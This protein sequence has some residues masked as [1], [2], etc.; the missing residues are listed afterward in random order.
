MAYKIERQG[1]DYAVINSETGEK[2]GTHSTRFAARAQMAVLYANVTEKVIGAD[3]E[4]WIAP[5]ST[6]AEPLPDNAPKSINLDYLKGLRPDNYEEFFRD[7]VAVKALGKDEIS[8]YV[9]L[10]GDP[11][12]VDLVGDYFTPQTDF[13]DKV[14][15][16]PR[17]L[18]WN[19]GTDRATLKAADV[20]GTMVEFTDDN[21][22]RAYRAI[23][24]RGHKYR[25]MVDK[26]IS[27]RDLGTSSDSAPQY[28]IRE[29]AGKAQ[30]IKQWPLFGAALTDTPC[31]P[32]MLESVNF[33]A[34]GQMLPEATD[35]E[36]LRKHAESQKRYFDYLLSTMR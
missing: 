20:L 15:S 24:E 2:I 26:L 31:E 13:W 33:K 22:G 14:L 3:S 19:H 4:A 36:R 8:G 7:V 27:S 9:T 10:W 1:G 5:D 6:T 16:L 29:V 12:K 35:L 28:V 21:V 30:W 34:I 32:R 17:P 25:A 23:L 18:T 11:A